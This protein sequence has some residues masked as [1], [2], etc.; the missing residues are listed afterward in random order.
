MSDEREL[1][2]FSVISEL[3]FQAAEV[4]ALQSQLAAACARREYDII[5]DLAANL[6]TRNERFHQTY[7]RLLVI[8]VPA[9]D[10]ALTATAGP[11]S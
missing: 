1:K 5:C 6:I 11:T 7:A 2:A 8:G 3:G 10:R 9:P 4:R